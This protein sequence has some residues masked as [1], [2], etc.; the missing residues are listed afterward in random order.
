MAHHSETRMPTGSS[1]DLAARR[2]WRL[3]LVGAALLAMGLVYR[4]GPMLDAP[5]F[6]EQAA[7][8]WTEA[9]WLVDH[10]FDYR[11]L[12]YGEAHFMDPEAGPRAYMISLL[13]SALAVAMKAS[14]SATET[15]VM[16][17]LGAFALTAGILVLIMAL[18][19][20]R[21]GAFRALLASSVFV[22]TPLV[23]TQVEMVG[24]EIPL[25][26]FVMLAAWL[27]DRGWRRGAAVATFAAFLMKSTGL[28]ATLAV[29]ILAFGQRLRR[30]ADS[31]TRPRLPIALPLALLVIEGLLI[32]WG[33]TTASHRANVRN[34]FGGAGGLLDIRMIH[35]WAPDLALAM[36][37]LVG[38]TVIGLIGGAFRRSSDAPNVRVNAAEAFGV[39][40]TVLILI[41]GANYILTPRYLALTAPFI[42]IGVTVAL[43]RLADRAPLGRVGSSVVLAG[44]LAINVANADG[45]LFPAI[46]RI[47]ARNFET[48]AFAH[49]RAS[50]ILERSLEYRETLAAMRRATRSLGESVA[51]S[52]KK[53]TPATAL[54]GYPFWWYATKPRLGYVEAPLSARRI[55]ST[56]DVV[57]SL[58]QSPPT[59]FFWIWYGASRAH[60]PAEGKGVGL[61]ESDLGGDLRLCQA[62]ADWSA[63]AYLA[64]LE[65][66]RWSWFPPVRWA[67]LAEH[68]RADQALD[69]IEQASSEPDSARYQLAE[70]RTGIEA[71]REAQRK[72]ARRWPGL[73]LGD[74][75][76]AVSLNEAV[77]DSM[78]PQAAGD[79]TA[80]RRW[81]LAFDE[82]TKGQIDDA[83]KRLPEI[84]TGAPALTDE[85]ATLSAELLIQQGDP[86][87][88]LA[89]LEPVAPASA[90]AWLAR[91]VAHARLADWP[92]ARAAFRD[93]V[94]L[95][96]DWKLAREY[97]ARARTHEPATSPGRQE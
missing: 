30:R 50:V 12:R 97:L 81:F 79:R 7:G 32:A 68:G 4:H 15:V 87:E 65:K 85:V 28:L 2:E 57:D 77:A 80:P 18:L 49:R 73:A 37:A 67:Y 27:L 26:F 36:A 71:I 39:I 16:A 22:T 83:A 72:L 33:D 56:Q 45:R 31:D 93:A 78:T 42:V 62:Q 58:T 43:A 61:L 84:A 23:A 47:H 60:L 44:W 59:T 41:A 89:T 64:A 55:Q 9:D 6:E 21:V 63:E 82:A 5:P 86:T 53:G 90:S 14:S 94:H 96:P 76:L 24:M 29:L 40:L 11:R 8:L 52:E 54:L 1:P 74:V 70:T 88:A 92:A 13:P 3:A 34:L 69:E 95:D 17:H 25:L 91:G 38:L 10:G 35:V 75:S 51:A 19:T 46:D 66:S 48:M 20:P